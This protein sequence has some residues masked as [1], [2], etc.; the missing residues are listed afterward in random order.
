MPSE[1]VICAL[2]SILKLC[3]ASRNIWIEIS[4]GGRLGTLYL[5]T[6]MEPTKPGI[7]LFYGGAKRK[8]QCLL[9]IHDDSLPGHCP[10]VQNPFNKMNYFHQ[11][12]F[13]YLSSAQMC[14]FPR[15]FYPSSTTSFYLRGQLASLPRGERSHYLLVLAKGHLTSSRTFGKIVSVTLSVVMQQK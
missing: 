15:A 11:R 1:S 2:M 6:K 13:G 10:T 3:W 8:K 9:N 12:N 5:Q 14:L 7:C 4:L